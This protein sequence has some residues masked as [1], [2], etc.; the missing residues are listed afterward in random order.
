MTKVMGEGVWEWAWFRV[1]VVYGRHGLE[2][3]WSI[4]GMVGGG[5]P[6]THHFCFGR[7]FGLGSQV[8]FWPP[9]S[10]LPPL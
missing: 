7:H 2:W 1:G 9:F 5:A 6:P 4:A 8:C 3:V 10:F